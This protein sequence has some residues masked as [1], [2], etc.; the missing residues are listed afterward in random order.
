MLPVP[1]KNCYWVV[2]G[3]FLAGEYPRDVDETASV[4][5]LEALITAGVRT[6]IDLTDKNDQLEPYD[7]MLGRQRGVSQI[8]FPIRDFSIP[9]SLEYTRSIL[10]SIDLSI[11]ERPIVYLH[12]WGGVGRTGLIVGCWLGRHGYPGQAGYDR[13][14]EL[15]RQCPKSVMRKSPET[16]EQEQ[17]ILGWKEDRLSK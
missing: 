5:K 15:W 17:Y 10:N 2:P 9:D 8:R 14:Q 16:Y 7:S 4:K 3:K 12:C 6:F 1:I 11:Q 13:L